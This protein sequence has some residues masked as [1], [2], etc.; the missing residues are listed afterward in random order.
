MDSFPKSDLQ[1]AS[2]T[3]VIDD[4][5]KQIRLFMKQM[6]GRALVMM[7]SA[8][9]HHDVAR[10]IV[11]ES[12]ISLYQNYAKRPFAEWTPLFYTILNHRLMDW[13][14]QETRKQKR[15]GW[16]KSL[17]TDNDLN[18]DPTLAIEDTQNIDPSDFLS[19]SHTMDEIR[20]AV[21]RLPVRQQQAFLLRAWE[22]LDT[23]TTAKIMECSEG[24]VKT[25]YHRAIQALRHS[26]S[27][28]D[29]E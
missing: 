2:I 14:R 18:D 23:R 28:L 16:F 25:H 5:Q 10:D 7:E 8:T 12:F 19:K 6:S 29:A 26:L 13:H 4:D 9:G 21:S 27:Q 3:S 11:Q 20:Q 17:S 15:F 22:N 1:D 24:S